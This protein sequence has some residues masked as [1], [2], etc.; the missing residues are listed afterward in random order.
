M[1]YSILIV[2]DERSILETIEIGF[3]QKGF[4]VYTALTGKAALEIAREKQFQ[5]ALI[6][7][8]LPDFN[9]IE[10]SKKIKYYQ[11]ELITILMTGYP[12]IKSA[13]DAL[14]EQVFDY[15]IKPFVFDQ[16]LLVIEKARKEILTKQQREQLEKKIAELQ[17]EN[18]QLKAMIREL[19]PEL[20][21]SKPAFHDK[22]R[23][24]LK[25]I[26]SAI[27]VYSQSSL[28]PKQQES[29]EDE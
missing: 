23:Y 27:S 24:I 12:G 28:K 9:G 3:N 20:K 4:I 21:H 18:L 7:I 2:D 22:Y 5:F 15:L 10:L 26:E 8:R 25:N 1:D 6:D 13:V 29:D 17:A 14:R 16:V 19:E 11:P